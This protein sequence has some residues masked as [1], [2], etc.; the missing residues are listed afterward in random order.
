[1]QGRY[2]QRFAS[3]TDVITTKINFPAAKEFQIQA[4]ISLMLEKKTQDYLA[5]SDYLQG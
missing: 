4:I 2:T 3:F 5:G 1:M